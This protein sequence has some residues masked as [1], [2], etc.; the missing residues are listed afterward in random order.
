MTNEEKIKL[1]KVIYDNSYL[2]C[3]KRDVDF[4]LNLIEKQQQEIEYWK[5]QAEGYSGLAKQIEQDYRE[6]EQE[7]II[8]YV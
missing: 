2:F 7:G 6:M 1:E 3:D 8:K 4:L 5:E